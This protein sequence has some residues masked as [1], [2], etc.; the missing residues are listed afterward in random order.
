MFFVSVTRLRLRSWRFFPGFLVYTFAS[1]RQISHAGGF[2]TGLLAGDA[3]RGSWT[4]TVW[5]DEQSMRAFRTSGAHMRA[6]PKLL[7]WCDE[8][9]V[10]HWTQ[11][12][13]DLPSLSVAFERMRDDGR[14][15]K[16]RHP[17][18][19]QSSGIVVGSAAPRPGL[20]LRPRPSRP[21]AP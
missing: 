18:A 7:D 2:V 19:R 8:A 17:S 21:T 11:E 10:A 16:V 3:E 4:V 9:S 20:P 12:R 15:S 5:R 13:H 14:I 6:M 1:S